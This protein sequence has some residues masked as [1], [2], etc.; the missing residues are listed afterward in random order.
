MLDGIFSTPEQY[1]TEM[2]TL[3][4]STPASLGN[5]YLAYNQRQL[6]QM[7][8]CFTPNR[9]IKP[10]SWDHESNYTFMDFHSTFILLDEV[11]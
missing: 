11:Q 9:N 7:F 3:T 4:E 2:D 8:I 10:V 1:D 6:C 5:A